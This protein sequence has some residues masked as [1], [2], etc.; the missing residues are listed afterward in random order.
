M[1]A[2]H[3]FELVS[4]GDAGYNSGVQAFRVIIPLPLDAEEQV[5]MHTLGY[6]FANGGRQIVVKILDMAMGA[7]LPGSNYVSQIFPGPGME[8]ATSHDLDPA[9]AWIN[10]DD[11]NV[12]V[13]FS[14]MV[15]PD[16]RTMV[17]RDPIVANKPLVWPHLGNRRPALANIDTNYGGMIAVLWE[18]YE[19]NAAGYPSKEIKAR[20]F[21][22]DGS[23]LSDEFTVNATLGR[24]HRGILR[25]SRY[26]VAPN[27]VE[28]NR[29]FYAVWMDNSLEAGGDQ[30]PDTE[31]WRIKGQQWTFDRA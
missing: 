6:A 12:M 7:F 3:K 25:L 31:R 2:I 27:V 21:H 28:M 4:L 14:Q 5:H 30:E 22:I 8:V 24:R 15:R 16:Y 20:L 18:G 9:V 10:C 1:P 23:P 17:F 19:K 29:G 11:G 13:S 26:Q